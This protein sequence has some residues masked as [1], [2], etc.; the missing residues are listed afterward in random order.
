MSSSAAG[1][2]GSVGNVAGF[3]EGLIEWGDSFPVS[4]MVGAFSVIARMLPAMLMLVPHIARH[5]P[6]A[7]SRVG[8]RLR[9]ALRYGHELIAF[10]GACYPHSSSK[11]T[12]RLAQ[13]LPNE[14]LEHYDYGLPLKASRW[15]Q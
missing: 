10:T 7:A 15:P 5:Q 4:R 1:R 3:A 14:A 2:T 11:S 12:Y 9:A 6:M 8:V 13:Y